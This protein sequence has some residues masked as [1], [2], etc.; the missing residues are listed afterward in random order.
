MIVRFELARI[1]PLDVVK[2]V[3]AAEL[4]TKFT[5]TLLGIATMV[6]EPDEA[7]EIDTDFAEDVSS[8]SAT[9]IDLFAIALR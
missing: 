1:A 8:L 7:S 2:L 4:S 9:E 6:D 5:V 3:E